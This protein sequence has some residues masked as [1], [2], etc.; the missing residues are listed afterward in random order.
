M[1]VDIDAAELA[2]LAPHIQ[3]PIQS[4][5]K[6]FIDAL[7]ARRGAVKTVDRS[8]WDRRCAD[9]KTRYPIV[10]AK[11]RDPA[12]KVSIYHLADVIG[13]ETD[14]SDVMP[15]TSPVPRNAMDP[16]MTFASRNGPSTFTSNA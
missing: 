16:T 13:S 1:A 12:T 5:A 4:D 7:L 11:H 9:W 8:E 10:T 3:T 14:A 15:R 2:K 6:A